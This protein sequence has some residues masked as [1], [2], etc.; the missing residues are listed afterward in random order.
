MAE[1]IVEAPEP[2]LPSDGRFSPP[3]I[4]FLH[5]CLRKRPEERLPADILLGTKLSFNFVH[6]KPNTSL[7]GSPWLKNCGVT[8]LP[9]AVNI[10]RGWWTTNANPEALAAT[11]TALSPL[12]AG[13]VAGSSAGAPRAGGSDSSAPLHIPAGYSSS[14]A[15][16]AAARAVL[17]VRYWYCPSY[18]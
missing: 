12:G 9:A 6:P 5:S 11:G 13:N 8:G 14:A 10:I 7:P 3:F 16:A 15:S 17:Q 18:L 4:E 1:T 2:M